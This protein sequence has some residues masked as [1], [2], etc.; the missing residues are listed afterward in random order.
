MTQT[1]TVTRGSTVSTVVDTRGGYGLLIFAPSSASGGI[2][3]DVAA[4]PTGPWHHLNEV[5]GQAFIVCSG[6]GSAGACPAGAAFARIRTSG[7]QAV[8]VDFLVAERRTSSR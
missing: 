1:C 8:T 6:G 3:L 7:P 2:M 5:G 4:T